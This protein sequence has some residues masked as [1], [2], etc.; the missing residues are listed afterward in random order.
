MRK[1]K[2]I[3]FNGIIITISSLIMQ[4]IGFYF[5]IYISNKVGSEALGIFNII[6]SI[7]MFF[8]TIATFGINISTI[9][10]VVKEKSKNPNLSTKAMM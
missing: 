2:I 7:Y 5:M 9:R 4:S 1:F 10:L 6:M 3:I 8:I